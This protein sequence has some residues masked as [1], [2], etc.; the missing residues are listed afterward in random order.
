MASHTPPDCVYLPI[1]YAII[2]CMHASECTDQPLHCISVLEDGGWLLP[3][4]GESDPAGA[5]GMCHAPLNTGKK[6]HH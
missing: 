5:L 3:S 6:M 2:I 1:T 4:T